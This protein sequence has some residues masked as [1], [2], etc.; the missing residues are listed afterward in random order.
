MN[1]FTPV[2]ESQEYLIIIQNITRESQRFRGI[3][4]V[5]KTRQSF[6]C[7]RSARRIRPPPGKIFRIQHF[8]NPMILNDYYLC[9]PVARASQGHE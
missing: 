8:C 2:R 7:S 6:P 1:V 5:K 4:E 3:A 9:P